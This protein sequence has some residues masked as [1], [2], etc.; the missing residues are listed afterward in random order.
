LPPL[1]TE[2]IFTSH[3]PPIL[4]G[5]S[6]M[7][8]FLPAALF[9]AAILGMLSPDAAGQQKAKEDPK[10]KNKYAPPAAVK[11]DAATL[12]KI[13][14]KSAELKTAVEGLKAK[15]LPRDVVDEVEIYLKGAQNIVRFGEWYNKDSGKWALTTLDRG[16]ERAKQAEGG[17]AVWRDRPGKW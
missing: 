3:S 17:K 9:L 2:N 11:P 12:T 14:E 8:T 4:P 15:K 7:R 13:A 1:T 16:L 5:K 10:A 6:L